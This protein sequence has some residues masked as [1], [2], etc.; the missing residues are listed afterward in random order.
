MTVSS[1]Q[2]AKRT[3][4]SILLKLGRQYSV[5]VLVN[6]DSPDKDVQS[7][8]RRVAVKAHPD[9]GGSTLHT[10]ELLTARENWEK[11]KKAQQAS[12]P[13]AQHGLSVSLPKKGFR[14]QSG[15]VLL[16]FSGIRDFGHWEQYLDFLKGK[17][18][19]WKVWRWCAT[20]EESRQKKLHIHTMFQFFGQVDWESARFSFQGI[21]PNAGPNGPGKDLCGQGICRKKYQRSVDRGM[22][23]CYANKKGTVQDSSGRPVWAGNYAPAWEEESQG[24]Y[25]VDKEWAETLWKQYKL[26]YGPYEEYLYKSRGNI[27]AQKRTLDDFRAWETGRQEEAEIKEVVKRIKENHVLY[28]P[29]VTVPAATDWLQR[30]QEDKLRYP[31]LIVLGPSRSGKT[32]WVKSLFANPLELKIGALP[33]FPDAMRGFRRNEHDALILDDVRDLQFLADNQDKLQGKYDTRVEFATTAGG[34]CAYRKYLFATPAAVTIN[35]STANL[36]FLDSHDWLSKPE[37]RVLIH[38]DGTFLQEAGA[39]TSSQAGP[40]T[41]E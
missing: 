40:W 26:D 13:P 1:V 33:H 30:F 38:F 31:I 25:A 27:Y 36:H 24:T 19:E 7:A 12:P 15:A 21:A 17:L 14:I 4:V 35:F 11:A 32:D 16:T 3:L 2:T 6:R 20:L 39:S 22:F 28:R 9:K 18:K 37:N 41:F 23:Y 5:T 10:Q 8:F 29:F 34:T